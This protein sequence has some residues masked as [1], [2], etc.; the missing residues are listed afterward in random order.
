M[1]G[2]LIFS[3]NPVAV[4]G[5]L[6]ANV[7]PA[8]SQALAGVLHSKGFEVRDFDVREDDAEGL[9]DLFGVIGGLLCVR[10]FSTGEERMYS[11][12]SG[13]AWLGAFLMDLGRGHFASAARHAQAHAAA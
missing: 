12:G 10:C 11:T 1:C 13:S 4:M 8:T 6:A 5:Q 9:S 7:P 3:L 2:N